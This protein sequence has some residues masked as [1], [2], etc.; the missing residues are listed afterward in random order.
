M[1]TSIRSLAPPLLRHMQCLFFSHTGM[2]V[3]LLI[4]AFSAL[5]LG[6]YST[7]VND[8][9]E[10]IASFLGVP[11]YS[12]STSLYYLLWNV[13][14][15]RILLAILVGAALAL[16]GAAIQ[17]L[18]R[19]PLADPSLIGVTS[20]A[21]VFAV[22]GIVLGNSLLASF[23][24]AVG[25][26]S[27]LILAFMGSLSTTY[28]VYRLASYRGK[29]MVATMLLAGIAVAALAGALTGLM[30]Y[31]SSEEELRDITFWTLGSVGGA[32]WS[33][34]AYMVPVFLLAALLL[35]SVHKELDL[36]SLG[37]Q[38]AI[39]LG[40]NIQRVK[41]TVIGG[42]ALAVGCSVALCG[43]IGFIALVVPHLI[44]LTQGTSHRQLL[45]GAALLGGILLLIADT[46]AR[47]IIAPAELPIG[48]LTAL[49][50]APFFI[51]ILLQTKRQ[52]LNI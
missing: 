4:S 47:T 39:Y 51:G 35:F 17:G 27:T 43:M 14:L 19:N 44:R 42:A 31:F 48:I 21:M 38:E 18:F 26:I 49:L 2:A 32:S 13:R 12:T 9:I 20:G 30:T 7:G 24:L 41:W 5:F 45:P 10:S 52:Y 36:L 37:E 11:G 16:S 34:L 25:F 6:A 40:V 8:V 1:I 33:M 46:F 50:G 29:T 3:V 28:L 23:P 22:A 15:P